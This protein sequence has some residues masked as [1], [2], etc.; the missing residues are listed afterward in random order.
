[1]RSSAPGAKFSTSTSQA[2]Q[3]DAR[4]DAVHK[5]AG[6]RLQQSRGDVECR[7]RQADLDVADA[8]G[9]AHL[10]EQRRQQH[11]VHVAHE[12]RHGDQRDHPGLAAP[13][14]AGG[15]LGRQGERFTRR[16]H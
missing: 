11:D 12:M 15:G 16:R 6:R 13:F 1:M 4:T 7:Q 3:H 9:L 5:E 14:P 2:G 10:A 8:E